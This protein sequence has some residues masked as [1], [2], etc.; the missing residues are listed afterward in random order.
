MPFPSRLLTD[1]EEVVVELRP[2]WVTLGWPLVAAVAAIVLAISVVATFPSI[3]IGVVYVLVGVVVITALW[4]AGRMV[5]WFST[6]L[7]VT[8]GRI[9]QRS[10][11]LARRGLELRL[12]RVNQLSYHQS[13]TGRVLR[14]GELLVEMGGEMGVVAFDHVPRPAVVQSLITEQIDALHRR[15][16][17]PAEVGVSVNGAATVGADTPPEGTEAVVGPPPGERSVGE[18]LV[19]LHELRRRGIVT[20]DEFQAKKADLLQLL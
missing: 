7:V 6:S 8:T 13:L 5:R 9:V 2:H 20:D 4:L 18:R 16:R 1:G 14:T 15:S 12:E 3:P 11:V 17:R 10:G 19:E